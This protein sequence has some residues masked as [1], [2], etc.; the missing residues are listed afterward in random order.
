[1]ITGHISVEMIPVHKISI[2]TKTRSKARILWKIRTSKILVG[3]HYDIWFKIRNVG[4]KDF[5][6]GT[7]KISIVY[8]SKQRQ[9]IEFPVDAIEKGKETPFIGSFSEAAMDS[10]YANFL[11]EIKAKDGEPVKLMREG[12]LLPP[13]ATFHDILI[14]THADVYG[15]WVLIG[16][17][18]SIILGI[19]AFL[20]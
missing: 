20:K 5:P 15:R 7:I 4:E 3:E 18:A 17:M 11:G 12:Q 9:V 13:G 1:M 16:T 14:K 19:L 8:K 10:G 2:E 6:G